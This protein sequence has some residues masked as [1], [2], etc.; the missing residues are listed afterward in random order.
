MV[1][2]LQSYLQSGLMSGMRDRKDTVVYIWD[3]ILEIF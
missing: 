3:E 1:C 2:K